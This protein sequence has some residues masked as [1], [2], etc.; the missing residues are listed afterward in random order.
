MDA[1]SAFL[2][3][4]LIIVIIAA[5]FYFLRQRAKSK[6]LNEMYGH[7]PSHVELYFEEY[8]DDIIHSW[9]LV[10]KEKAH[11]WADSMDKRLNEVSKEIEQLKS[12]RKQI[13]SEF[14][15]IENR[16]D[17]LESKEVRK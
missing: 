14:D 10:K 15:E 7:K 8:F 16:I 2:L 3:V 11:N 9:D 1:L 6:A 4:I 5:F 12:N 13:D 17:D